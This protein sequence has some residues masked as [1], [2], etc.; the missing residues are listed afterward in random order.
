METVKIEALKS[1][2]RENP[3]RAIGN[4]LST[5]IAKETYAQ[6]VDGLPLRHV[7]LDCYIGPVCFYHPLLEE[8]KDLCPDV[9]EEAE[10]L[11]SSFDV[12]TLLMPLKVS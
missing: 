7:A 8:H 10:T 5:P 9:S 4:V 12:G 1:S 2:H 3:T 6:I 11:C